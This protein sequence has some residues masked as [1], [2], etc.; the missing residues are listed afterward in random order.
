MNIEDVDSKL[1]EY[2]ESM[3]RC[4]VISLD[5]L[6]ESH[7]SLREFRKTKHQEWLNILH[8]AR[9]R[10]FEEGKQQA[11]EYNYIDREKLKEMTINQLM[12]LLQ[13]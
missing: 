9:K 12:E 3:S 8:E 11:L 10:G 13:N 6:I 4:F 5:E 2:S 1:K 7:R